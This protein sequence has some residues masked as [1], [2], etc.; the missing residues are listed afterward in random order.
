MEI[1]LKKDKENKIIGL[2][3]ILVEAFDFASTFILELQVVYKCT[4]NQR[5]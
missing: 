4:Y 1:V 3:V 2:V 5:C